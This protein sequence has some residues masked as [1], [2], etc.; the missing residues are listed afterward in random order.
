VDN[1]GQGT[2]LYDLAMSLEWVRAWKPVVAGVREVFHA[3]FLDQAHFSRHFK[4]HVGAP[5]GRYAAP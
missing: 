4:R 2:V 3:R 1:G 5:P